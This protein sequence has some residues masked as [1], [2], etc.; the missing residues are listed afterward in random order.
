LRIQA[1]AHADAVDIRCPRNGITRTVCRHGFDKLMKMGNCSFSWEELNKHFRRGEKV[2]GGLS[3]RM[4]ESAASRIIFVAV[5]N[6]TLSPGDSLMQASFSQFDSTT[7]RPLK[8][9]FCTN[10]GLLWRLSGAGR[11]LSGSTRVPSLHSHAAVAP[12]GRNK[13]AA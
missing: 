8:L 10:A 11:A 9:V 1:Y 12:S 3:V 5:W 4:R 2:E 13:A 6:D 7:L